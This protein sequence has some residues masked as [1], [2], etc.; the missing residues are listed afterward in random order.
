MHYFECGTTG[1][2]TSPFVTLGIPLSPWAFPCHPE[3][4]EGSFIGTLQITTT[5]TYG[6]FAVS[7][8]FLWFLYKKKVF[9]K[10]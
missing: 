4:S 8:L 3:R 5:Q 10:V 1:H 6:Y 9:L 2:H 7:W